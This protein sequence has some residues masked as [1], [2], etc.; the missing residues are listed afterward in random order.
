MGPG[1]DRHKTD[2]HGVAPANLDRRATV[3]QWLLDAECH[4]I[5]LR[6][7]AGLLCDT[8]GAIAFIRHN[9]PRR[10]ADVVCK[11][12]AEVDRVTAQPNRCGITRCRNNPQTLLDAD[13]LDLG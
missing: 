6:T 2:Q 9:D 10:A 3:I 5:T 13:A 11:D 8:D 1:I 12:I 7:Q 4:G